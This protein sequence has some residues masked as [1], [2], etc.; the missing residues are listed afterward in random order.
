MKKFPKDPDRYRTICEQRGHKGCETMNQG[1]DIISCSRHELDLHFLIALVLAFAWS[2]RY[3]FEPPPYAPSERVKEG[4]QG[5]LDA[6][7]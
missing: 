5:F 2:L 4:F 7:K 6:Q 3:C 1:M